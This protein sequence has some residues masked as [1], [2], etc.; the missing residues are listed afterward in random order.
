MQHCYKHMFDEAIAVCADCGGRL[1]NDC[2]VAV[3]RHQFCIPCAL[4]RSGVN[5]RGSALSRTR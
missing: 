1:C 5:H 4:V 3:K 2:V